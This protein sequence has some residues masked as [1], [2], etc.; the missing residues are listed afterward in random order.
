ML[1]RRRFIQLL[2][3]GMAAGNLLSLVTPQIKAVVAAGEVKRTPVLM[4]EVGS[5]TGDSVSLWHS[6]NPDF[7]YIISNILEWRYDTTLMQSGG[8]KAYK[9]LT[10]TYEKDAQQYILIIQGSIVQRDKGNYNQIAYHDNKYLTGIDL[11]TWLGER[12]KYV[13][14]I[15]TCATHGGPAAAHPNPS[16]STGVQKIL[17]RRKV[18]NVTGCP[19]YSEWTM[20]TLLHL[21]LYGEPELDSFNRPLMFYGKTI[22]DQCERRSFYE[23]GIFAAAFG[24]KECLYKV[25]CK[26]P[27]TFADCPV[28]HWHDQKN[29]PVS[30]NSPCIGCTEPL[31]PD[32]MSPF[33]AHLPDVT[34]PGGIMVTTEK[35]G[36]GVLAASALGITAHLLTG[37]YNGRIPKNFLV[38]SIRTPHRYPVKKVSVYHRYHLKSYT[39]GK[40]TFIDS[41][42]IITDPKNP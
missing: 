12:A 36:L 5:C 25:G 13:V 10:D 35:I 23:K 24:D 18:I 2:L 17:P 19:A 31:F 28:R 21:A 39:P 27:V 37:F 40:N 3:Q 7:R 14:A 16:R 38:S 20:G 34:L 42:Q 15:G 33:H 6:W 22:H 41:N 30:C 9:L 29:W 11:V 32:Q 1:S 26:G 8:E 4:I